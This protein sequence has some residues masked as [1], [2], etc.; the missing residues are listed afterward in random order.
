[1]SQRDTDGGGVRAELRVPVNRVSVELTLGDGRCLRGTVFVP[2]GCHVEE[3]LGRSAAFLPV[4]QDG[5]VVL[6][7]PGAIACVAVR[8]ETAEPHP[9]DLPLAARALAVRLRSGTVV[10]GE[11]RYVAWSGA[12]RTADLLNEPAATIALYGQRG[13][14]QHVAKAHVESVEEVV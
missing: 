8:E 3:L 1:M 10:Q 2:P 12:M 11:V 14:V 4:E 13:V 7:A 9:D 5:T 6:Y